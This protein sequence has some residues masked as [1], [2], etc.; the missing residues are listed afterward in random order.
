MGRIGQL[1]GAFAFVLVLARLGRLLEIGPNQPR[2]RLILAAAVV[3]GAV[4]WWLLNQMTSNRRL[5]LTIF[6]LTG[7]I[8]LIRISV[9]QTLFAGVIPTSETMGAFATEMDQAIRL[10]RHGVPPVDATPGL[11]GILAV[12]VWS[13]GAL[14]SWGL[15]GGPVAAMVVPSAVVYLQFAIYDRVRGGVGWMILSTVM[16]AMTITAIGLERRRDTGRARDQSGR[17]IARRSTGVALVMAATLGVA[18]LA[19]A[20]SASRFVSE[21][22]NYPWRTGGSGYG[23]GSGGTRPDLFVGLRQSLID[24]DN[25]LLFSATFGPDSPPA[26]EIYWRLRTLDEFDGTEWKASSVGTSGYDPDRD[27]GSPDH[28]YQG[29]SVD[30]RHWVLIADLVGEV[31]PTAGVVTKVE[32]ASG[33]IGP[34][35]FEIAQQDSSLVYLPGLREGDIYQAVSNYALEE[36][37]V[38]LLA[39]G[40]DGQLTPIFANAVAAGEFEAAP[41]QSDRVAVEPENL[42]F[43]TQL[44]DDRPTSLLGVATLRTLGASTDYERAWM[45]Q[46]WFRDSGDFTY[47]TDV[48]TGHNALR[49]EDWLT[50]SGSTN[51]REGYCEQFATSMAVLGRELNIP[52]RVVIGF[53]P[54]NLV[55]RQDSGGKVID[56]VE[57][58]DTNLHAWVEMWIDPVGW[59]RFDPTPRGAFQPPSLTAAFDPA[60]FIPEDNVVTE[61]VDPGDVQS[62]PGGPDF[63]DEEPIVGG[64]STQ[65]RWWLLIVPGLAVLV[66][67]VPFAKTIRRRRRLAQIRH[68]DI[69]AAWTE[70]VDR[71]TDLGE[72]V[73]PSKTPVE[74]AQ[75][76]DP[77]LLS[78]AMAY[79]AA[80]YGGRSIQQA[81][82]ELLGVEGWLQGRYDTRERMRAA[83]NPR[84]LGRRD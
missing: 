59:V 19:T 61:P 76:F 30:I 45:L 46:Y 26:D 81:E 53:T 65:S 5:A 84:S 64:T 54:G 3:L 20:A 31:V 6:A 51:F 77:A 60:E 41:D 10:I 48:S 24:R 67:L 4:L 34:Q 18:A 33:G 47:S 71:L 82:A 15:T 9:P 13:I 22:G 57:M 44:P 27:V 32:P 62:G 83:L 2:W 16:L 79:S 28:R 49:L 58:R 8:L 70:L 1:T 12:L 75:Q 23:L 72:E 56:V 11:V 50:D 43:Y 37:D 29:S 80:I 14:Y 74:V 52:S 35:N 36:E 66:S 73:A 25:N 78:I 39:T 55:Q 40:E 7:L 38:G 42:E 21:Y 69:G 68:G 63:V 17:P